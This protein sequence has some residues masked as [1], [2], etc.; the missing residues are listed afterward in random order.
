MKTVEEIAQAILQ[1]APTELVRFR[2]W[3]DEFEAGHFDT[4]I[5]QDALAG[6]LDRFADEA[7]AHLAIRKTI[8]PS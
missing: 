3:F 2:V 6:R 8:R 7:L 4:A 1:L 5:E